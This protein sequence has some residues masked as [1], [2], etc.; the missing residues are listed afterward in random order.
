M[1]DLVYYMPYSPFQASYFYLKDNLFFRLFKNRK[2]PLYKIFLCS[3]KLIYF[4][5]QIFLLVVIAM[6]F[7]V[8]NVYPKSLFL[9][10]LCSPHS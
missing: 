9:V 6:I 2:L 4:R 3:M 7:D 5:A 10:T 1:M 8:L